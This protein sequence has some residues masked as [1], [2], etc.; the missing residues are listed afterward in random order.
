[1][2]EARRPTRP[3]P[4]TAAAIEAEL[5][6]RVRTD[7]AEAR[8]AN[9][10]E[11]SDAALATIIAR[12]I[13]QA[14]GFHLDAPEH[15]RNAV[16]GDWRSAAGPRGRPPSSPPADRPPRGPRP[17]NPPYGGNRP[18]SG[19]RRPNTRPSGFGPRRPPPK[20]SR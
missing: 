8:A 5:R 20:P 14:L 19:P 2:E 13:G 10:G 7:L 15:T 4:R 3:A 12:A 6:R 18:P 17:F 1:M 16:S 11:L 9:D